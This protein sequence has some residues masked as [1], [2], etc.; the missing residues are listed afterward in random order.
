MTSYWCLNDFFFSM[1]KQNAGWLKVEETPQKIPIFC[2]LMNITEAKTYMYSIWHG[3]LSG[4]IY[5]CF[6]RG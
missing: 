2:P 4:F 6:R 1:L 5:M 3:I